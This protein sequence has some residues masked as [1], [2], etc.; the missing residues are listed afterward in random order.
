MFP[1]HDRGVERHYTYGEC[2]DCRNK[3]R[4][5]AAQK[6]PPKLESF[7]T[8]R[9]CGETKLG[10]DFSLSKESKDGLRSICKECHS[11]KNK[12]AKFGIGRKE[13]FTLLKK[14]GGKCKICKGE[15]IKNKNNSK[16]HIDHCH[17]TGKVRGLLCDACNRGIGFLRDDINII[18]RAAEYVAEKGEI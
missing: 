8:C 5:K 2:K 12:K 6:N 3:R 14:Q 13:Y 10:K 4:R 9:E 17:K 18:K 1:S 11:F 15:D 16:F 7:K